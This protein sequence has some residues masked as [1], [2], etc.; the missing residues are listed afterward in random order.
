MA[1][2]DYHLVTRWVADGSLD[3]VA[4]LFRDPDGFA[5]WFP[6]AV[7]DMRVLSAGERNGIGM[8]VAARVQGWMPHTLTF[9]FRVTESHAERG[10]ALD[11]WGD[12]T[13]RLD[14]RI[15]EAEDCVTIYF[16]WN[17]RVTKPF[18]RYL[19]WLLRPFFV[20]NHLW[21]VARGQESLDLELRRR[22]SYAPPSPPLPEPPGPTFPHG[23][24]DAYVRSRAWSHAKR[25]PGL[26]DAVPR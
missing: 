10:F 20:S 3:E 25:L 1:L 2:H 16:D 11:V 7:R 22:R 14:C 6:A 5:R 23:R 18:V 4:A 26:P 19:S 9:W 8:V 13:G 12:F 17:V 24:L 15:A 21:V